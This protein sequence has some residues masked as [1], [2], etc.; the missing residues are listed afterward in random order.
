MVAASPVIGTGGS[1]NLQFGAETQVLRAAGGE[2]PP[3]NSTLLL[4]LVTLLSVSSVSQYGWENVR[5]P[6]TLFEGDTIYARS[7][8]LSKRESKSR[9]HM[10]LV[11]LK[12]IGFKQDGIA[13]IEFRRDIMIYKQGHLPRKPIPTPQN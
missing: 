9:Q 11:E 8:I 12:T 7:E 3:V 5:M 13:V 10:G 6:A 1:R 2:R 4:A